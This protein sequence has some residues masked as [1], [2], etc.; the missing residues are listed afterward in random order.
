[1][2]LQNLQNIPLRANLAEYTGEE[3]QQVV[4]LLNSGAVNVGEVSQYFNVPKSVVIGALADIPVDGEYTQE[5]ANKVEKLI[6]AGVASIGDIAENFKVAPSVIEEALVSGFNYNQAQITEA[7]AGVSVSRPQEMPVSSIPADGDYTQQEVNVVVNALNNNK[8]SAADVAAQFG[9]TEQQVKDELQRQNDVAATGVT[10]VPDPY[11]DPMP[12]MIA[13]AAASTDSATGTNIDPLAGTTIMVDQVT[14]SATPVAATP[15]AGTVTADSGTSVPAGF[16][17]QP[18]AMATTVNNVGAEIPIGLRGREMALKGGALGTI[19]MLNNL[20]IASR[21]DLNPYALAGQ[22]ALKNQRALSGLD[23]QD[24][25]DTA[26]QQS[27][28][29]AFLREQGER[30]ALRNAAATGGATGGN[31]LKELTRFNTGLAS[32]DLQNQIANI[33]ALTGVGFDAA[34]NQANINMETGLPAAQAISNLGNNLATGR[35]RVAE[36]LSDQYG[37]AGTDIANIL[38]AQGRN[39]STMIGGQT[40]NIVNAVNNAAANEAAAQTGFS[41]NLASN[42]ANIGGA[43]AGVQQVA[44]VVPNYTA[45]INNAIQG[46]ALGYELAGSPVAATP[47]SGP[48]GNFFGN[49]NNYYGPGGA[50]PAATNN[51]MMN[52]GYGSYGAPFVTT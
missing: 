20:N 23:G 21:A 37:A 14:G 3:I 8:V 7:Q 45:G 4:D 25:F 31:V 42:V 41:T 32:Q 38:G 10:P 33:N 29:M 11:A 6:S 22:D 5:E 28:Q 36:Q 46:A 51:N 40:S 48:M 50:I 30:A 16:S 9:V 52:Y 17:A 49:P 27:P 12:N 34:T 44:P 1:M 15:S 35:T 18:G 47:I 2:A 43:L 19:G 39:M 26:Y 13:R 24:A